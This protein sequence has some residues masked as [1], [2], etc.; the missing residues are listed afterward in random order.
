M[1]TPL[2]DRVKVYF[3]KFGIRLFCRYCVFYR[4]TCDLTTK[5]ELK[6]MDYSPKGE[7]KNGQRTLRSI[8]KGKSL[9]HQ[10]ML[11]E[12]GHPVR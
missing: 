10:M 12:Q 3:Q 7:K 5:S 4:E 9:L 11:V 8:L 6:Y 1:L 2:M